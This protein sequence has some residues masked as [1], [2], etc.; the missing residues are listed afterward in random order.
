M[1]FLDDEGCIKNLTKMLFEFILYLIRIS[2]RKIKVKKVYG[3][4]SV[5]SDLLLDQIPEFLHQDSPG[6]G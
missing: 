1:E 3:K 5:K 2:G 4:T 6:H